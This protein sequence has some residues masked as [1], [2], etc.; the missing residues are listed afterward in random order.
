MIAAVLGGI[1][2][3]AVTLV[4]TKIEPDAPAPPQLD[5]SRVKRAIEMIER[6]LGG[7]DELD[8]AGGG[9]LSYVPPVAARAADAPEVPDSNGRTQGDE[10]AVASAI[11]DF[12]KMTSEDL[13]LEA[14]ERHTRDFDIAGATKRYRELLSRASTPSDRRHWSIRL[15]DCLTR[16]RNFDEAAQAYRNC[17]D[18]STED[19]VERV[20]CMVA[21]ARREQPTNLVE[22][23]R[24]TDRALELESGRMNV[25]VHLVS[26]EIARNLKQ[27]DREIR[28]LE[29]LTESAPYRL[30]AW[31]LRLAEL[32][33]EKR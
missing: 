19:H 21:L 2:G 33:G 6:R 31:S 18:A 15:G 13:A 16:L 4:A 11:V 5:P 9:G 8:D 30:D 32:R 12:T 3:S 28:E 24:W 29:W 25:D 10:P 27:V 1:V 17:V 26:W 20:A 14:D 7:R 23:L 22:A